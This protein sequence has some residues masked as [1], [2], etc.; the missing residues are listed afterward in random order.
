M[1]NFKKMLNNVALNEK[2]IA[3]DMAWN[4]IDQLVE[5]WEDDEIKCR[6]IPIGRET[7][8]RPGTV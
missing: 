3:R 5:N 2:Q 6:C 1:S 7:R 4:A 8:L